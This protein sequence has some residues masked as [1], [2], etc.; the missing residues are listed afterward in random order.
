VTSNAQ[1]ELSA[2]ERGLH[3]L[4]SVA[5][6]ETLDVKAYAARVGRA[7]KTVSNEVWAARVVVA[8]ADVGNR[9]SLS[10]HFSQLVEIHAAPAWLWPALAEAMVAGGWT[11]EKTRTAVTRV[12]D[13]PG[14]LFAYFSPAIAARLVGGSLR[15]PDLCRME[16]LFQETEIALQQAGA[17]RADDRLAPI[18]ASRRSR[19]RSCLSVRRKFRTAPSRIY[20][21]ARSIDAIE[22]RVR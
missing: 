19:A 6:G 9:H 13:A 16:R 12:K 8:V 20:R 3:A 7:G 22:A 18:A 21:G 14:Q 10:R 11:V 5:D 15:P 1:S 4:H 17:E 2:L